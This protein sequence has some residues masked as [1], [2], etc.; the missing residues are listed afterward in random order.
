M[1]QIKPNLWWLQ[2]SSRKME[3]YYS[4]DS[5]TWQSRCYFTGNFYLEKELT[6]ANRFIDRSLIEEKKNCETKVVVV[7]K[8]N[9]LLIQYFID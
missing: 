3:K 1:Y 7:R 4:R 9:K 2:R 5:V 8:K 6:R